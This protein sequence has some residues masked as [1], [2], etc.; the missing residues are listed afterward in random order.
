MLLSKSKFHFLVNVLWP[1]L[2]GE[3]L[4]KRGPNEALPLSSSIRYKSRSLAKFYE[5]K[6]PLKASEK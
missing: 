6:A 4:Q 5:Q 2:L 1:N 3:E